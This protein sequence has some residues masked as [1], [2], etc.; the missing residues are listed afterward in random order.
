M[1]DNWTKLVAKYEPIIGRAY[2]FDGRRYVFFGLVHG[3]DDFYF[4]MVR[5]DGKLHLLS[6]VGTPEAFGYEAT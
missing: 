1:S 2:K 3:D 6:C 4:G 5:D